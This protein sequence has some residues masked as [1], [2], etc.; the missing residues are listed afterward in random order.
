MT[1]IEYV[2]NM[3]KDNIK[4]KSPVLLVG[5]AAIIFK[6]IYKGNIYR[7]YNTEDI[8]EFITNFYN[9]EYDKPLVVED[10]SILHNDSLLL[11]MIEE[12]KTPLIFLAT[13]D[14]LSIPLQ[15]RMKTYIKFPIDSDFSCS[16]IKIRE[17][18]E[19]I[20]N[21][22]MSTEELDKYLAENCPDLAFLYRDTRTK[23]Y[24]DKLIQIYGGLL[25]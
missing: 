5:G 14:N 4:E 16:F 11:K 2:Y 15:S 9:I 10:L 13:E 6:R 21:N 12:S 17:A 18:Q 22:D 7:V 20:D 25:S 3:M 24:K 8:K 19:Y 23:K 1:R